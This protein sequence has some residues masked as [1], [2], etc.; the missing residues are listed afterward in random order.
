MLPRACAI[1]VAASTIA[2]ADSDC[3]QYLTPDFASPLMRVPANGTRRV[4][5]LG[6]STAAGSGATDTAHSW[7]GLLTAALA[8][9]GFTV[10]NQSI[11]GTVT[12]DSLNRFQQDVVP[13][14]PDY[15]VL[16][17]SLWNENFAIDP[18][19]IRNT[20]MMNTQKLISMVDA[21]GAVPIQIGPYPNSASTPL[22][23]SI[24]G[25]IYATFETLGVPVWDFWNGMADARG[26]WL[27]GLSSDGTHPVDAG[28]RD[29]FD[30]VPNSYFAAGYQPGNGDP[31]IP[32]GS[33]LT[34]DGA[35][36]RVAVQVSQPL[37]SW[38]AAVWF[39]GSATTGPQ[40]ILSVQGSGRLRLLRTAD[41]YQ[42][43]L[44]GA[45]AFTAA[46]HADAEPTWHQA[47]LTYAQEPRLLS[48]Y[49]DG[50][51]LAS[52]TIGALNPTS[53]SLGGGSDPFHFSHFVIYRSALSVD[54]ATSLRGFDVLR[55]SIESWIKLDAE[56][57]GGL[58]NAAGTTTMANQ[59]G[60]WLFDPSLFVG[61]C[62]SP[63][64]PPGPERKPHQGPSR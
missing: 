36:G 25:E 44:S 33:W 63:H 13:Y 41:G 37:G 55:K 10:I 16:A 5:V 49:L 31:E 15:V 14:R 1:L 61:S 23:V 42:L 4:V 54:D 62:T 59:L 29:F 28:H 11:S 56:S 39:R 7:V 18:V 3:L 6:S 46:V 17:T 12:Q 45:P 64:S 20:Y 19:N 30:A 52:R 50:I 38:S 21:I 53:F 51:L 32:Q 22:A 43:D 9:Q 24:I 2:I 48:V 57:S 47:M 26:N 35:G 58:V 60:N 34:G 40:A 27:P 8:P